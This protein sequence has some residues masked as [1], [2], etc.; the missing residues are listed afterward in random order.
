MG[1]SRGYQWPYVR[2]VFG[3]HPPRTEQASRRLGYRLRTPPMCFG[4]A[5]GERDELLNGKEAA[6]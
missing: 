1:S 2:S 6:R 3:M 5:A 4:T